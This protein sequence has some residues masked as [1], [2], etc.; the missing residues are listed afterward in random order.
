MQLNPFCPADPTRFK[1]AGQRSFFVLGLLPEGDTQNI[2]TPRQVDDRTKKLG[3][4][5]KQQP[6]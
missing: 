4:R 5:L 3:P 1:M 6:N 2:S